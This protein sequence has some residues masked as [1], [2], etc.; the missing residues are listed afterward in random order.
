MIYYWDKK[1][2]KMIAC[3]GSWYNRKY[4]FVVS[5]SK[6]TFFTGCVPDDYYC[7]CLSNK[8]LL[9]KGVASILRHPV[10]ILPDL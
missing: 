7:A 6:Y 2:E 10:Y 1:F 9:Y 4:W 5:C 3:P 8:S